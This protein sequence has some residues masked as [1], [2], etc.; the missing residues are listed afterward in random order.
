MELLHISLLLEN[1]HISEV[2]KLYESSHP[3]SDVRKYMDTREFSFNAMCKYV[4]KGT[5]SHVIKV[6][7]DFNESTI[8]TFAE[9]GRWDK[10]LS[11]VESTLKNKDE[12]ENLF[13]VI[14]LSSSNDYYDK[15]V[16]MCKGHCFEYNVY[17][18]GALE[19][20][21]KGKPASGL[22]GYFGY[23]YLKK[24]LESV[25]TIK[26][27]MIYKE[28]FKETDDLKLLIYDKLVTLL[29]L[30]T[31]EGRK[32]FLRCNVYEYYT[33]KSKIVEPFIENI[34]ASKTMDMY[35]EEILNMARNYIPLNHIGTLNTNKIKQKKDMLMLNYKF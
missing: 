2:I 31:I 34:L 10:V 7:D 13:K 15:I 1:G 16:E 8:L 6:I 17:T 3:N 24:T 32:M 30:N 20:A 19:L 23:N 21:K 11:L 27:L 22:R 25:D 28:Y 35:D 29:D 9:E 12:E 4:S 26:L 5:F 14:I 18:T 33:Y